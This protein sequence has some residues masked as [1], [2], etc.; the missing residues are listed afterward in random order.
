MSNDKTHP[1]DTTITIQNIEE[2][3]GPKVA[4][5]AKEGNW[6]EPAIVHRQLAA[7]RRGQ[8]KRSA[9][10]RRYEAKFRADALRERGISY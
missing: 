4:K 3:W 6:P 1:L 5:L 2:A 10:A 9:A 7:V 8:R